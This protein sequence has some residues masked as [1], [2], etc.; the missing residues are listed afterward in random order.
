MVGNRIDAGHPAAAAY[1]ERQQ[2]RKETGERGYVAGSAAARDRMKQGE[3]EKTGSLAENLQLIPKDIRDLAD[4]TLAELVVIF[5]TDQ[6]FVDWLKAVK[7]IEQIQS[8]RMKTAEKEGHLVSRILV[9]IGVIDPVNTAHRRMLTAGSKTIARR[10]TSMWDAGRN[11]DECE[12]FVR[13]TI[14]SFIRPLKKR[15]V[16]VI[17]DVS[18]SE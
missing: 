3:A 15:M 7:D 2:K 18:E 1:L 9:E 5:G 6:R 12:E 13:D 10:L 4:K 17:K 8:N 14:G 11:L 16:K